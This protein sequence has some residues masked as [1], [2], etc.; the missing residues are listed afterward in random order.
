MKIGPTRRSDY[1]I[2]ALL[3]LA[4]SDDGITTAASIADG[5]EIPKGFLHQVL[6]TL[7]HSNLITSRRGRTGGYSLAREPED[8]SILEIM[9]ALEG[10]IEDGE[11]AMRGGPC[12]WE[13][14]CAMHWVWSEARA[15]LVE[16]LKAA[17]LADVSEADVAL[18]AGNMPAPAST[19][20]ARP[21]RQTSGDESNPNQPRKP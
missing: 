4:R 1:G 7:K 5:M 19:H 9:E 10:P 11:C 6:L 18:L 16:K 15:A 2:R 13:V 20:R 21:S 17:T 8:I 12:H 3:W 14:V